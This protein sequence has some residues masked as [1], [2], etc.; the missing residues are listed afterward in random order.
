[1]PRLKPTEQSHTD[2]NEKNSYDVTTEPKI[3]PKEAPEVIFTMEVLY[4]LSYP[5]GPAGT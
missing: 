2:K 1:M 5:G 3:D 4:Q